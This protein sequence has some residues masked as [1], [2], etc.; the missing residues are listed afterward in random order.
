MALKDP[1]ILIGAGVLAAFL[2]SSSAKASSSKNNGTGG[3]NGNSNLPNPNELGDEGDAAGPSGCKPG[4]IIQNGICIKPSQ[5]NSGGNNQSGNQS[6]GGTATAASLTI[7]SK[8]DNFTFGDKTGA[9]WWAKNQKTAQQW[10]TNGYD[11]AIQIAYGMLKKNKEACFKDFP[12]FDQPWDPGEAEF[13]LLNWIKEYPK[14]WELIWWL[15]NK[16][17]EK[18][19]LGRQT[20]TVNPKTFIY[21]YG[22]EYNFDDLWVNTLESLAAVLS[23]IELENPAGILKSQF[24]L[25]DKSYE[26]NDILNITTYLYSILFPNVPKEVIASRYDKGQINDKVF[27]KIWDYV[28]NLD[29]SL[30]FPF[31]PADY[32][33]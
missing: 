7:S 6:G 26:S 32:G 23:A 3:A 1:K 13:A 12:D 20:I 22:K 4:L 18:F 9:A 19:F 2:F 27:D 25:N 33:K 28:S 5:G 14:I 11:N 17:D 15:R 24:K 31:D 29:D 16:I 10:V 21:T 30:D 8:C